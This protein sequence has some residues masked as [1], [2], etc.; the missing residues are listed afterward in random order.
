MSCKHSLKQNL[1]NWN[2]FVWQRKTL[3]NNFKNYKQRVFDYLAE[4]V[5]SGAIYK[6]RNLIPLNKSDIEELRDLL[7]VQLGSKD[8]YDSISNGHDFGVFVRQI[9]GLDREAISALFADYLSQYNFNSKQQE[10]LH[11]IVDFVLQNGDID[12]DDLYDSEP[13]KY[14]D[15]TDIFVDTEPL[16]QFVDIFHNAISVAA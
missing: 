8:D 3:F 11:Q 13:F 16:Y 7:C 5:D 6:I 1:I 14:Q 2:N 9:V 12:Y 15:Y 10:F 4:H